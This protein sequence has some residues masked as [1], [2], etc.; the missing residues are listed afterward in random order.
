MTG[1]LTVAMT[2]MLTFAMTGVLIVAT[3]INGTGFSDPNSRWQ[4]KSASPRFS[5][6]C[7]PLIGCEPES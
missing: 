6:Q 4:F 1:M 3:T 2:G 5:I 7:F